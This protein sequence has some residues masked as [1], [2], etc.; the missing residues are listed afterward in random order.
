MENAYLESVEQEIWSRSLTTPDTIL[1]GVRAAGKLES[2]PAW[3]PGGSLRAEQES[4]TPSLLHNSN[5][6]FEK[7][8]KI[9]TN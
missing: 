6:G 4:W 3:L 7:L 5:F 8:V 9:K 2:D 1:P